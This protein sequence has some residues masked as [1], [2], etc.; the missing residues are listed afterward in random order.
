MVYGDFCVVLV[1]VF[2]GPCA[3]LHDFELE[4]AEERNLCAGMGPGAICL[5]E[6]CNCNE[7][8][9]PS[10]NG[11]Q[12]LQKSKSSSHPQYYHTNGLYISSASST[13]GKL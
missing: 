10:K 13:S 12:C 8:W 5:A 3:V 4:E 1:K 9:I 7:G 11:Q 2:G 6:Q